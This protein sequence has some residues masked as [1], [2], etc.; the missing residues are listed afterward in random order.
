[1]TR[2]GSPAAARALQRANLLD[3]HRD[4]TLRVGNGKGGSDRM[5]HDVQLMFGNINAD[6]ERGLGHAPLLG[7]WRLRLRSALQG[8]GL[9]GPGNCTSFGRQDMTTQLRYGLTRPEA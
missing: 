8:Y 5:D 6:I 3:K 7:T 1:M 9:G 2:T 4:P